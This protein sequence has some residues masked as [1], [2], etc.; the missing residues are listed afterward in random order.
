VTLKTIE[1]VNEL[2]E[3]TLRTNGFASGNVQKGYFETKSKENVKLI[4][5]GDQRPVILITNLRDKKIYYSA[6]KKS[7]E[8]IFKEL[9]KTFPGVE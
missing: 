2:P 1:I 5:N 8:D 7:N 3:I 4:I 6:K 9:K